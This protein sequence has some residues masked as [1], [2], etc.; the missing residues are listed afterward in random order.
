MLN[1]GSY[2]V[3]FLG[4]IGYE[5]LLWLLNQIARRYPESERARSIGI[6]SYKKSYWRTIKNAQI[7]LYLE[8]YFDLAFCAVLGSL[9]IKEY[10]DQGLM[11]D[12]LSNFTNCLEFGLTV[13]FTLGLVGFPL[14]FYI[15][16]NTNFNILDTIM[17]QK[18]YASMIEG[19]QTN[20]K[21]QAFY[22][23][24]FMVRRLITVIVL[25]FAPHFP[26][27]QSITLLLLSTVNLI[28]VT[29]AQPF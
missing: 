15:K 25:V 1:S 22:N 27:L 10:L 4:I 3:V 13:F 14:Y 5:I 19:L 12:Y 7:K 6:Y 28:Y 8:S 29:V 16:L 26:Y 20:Y 9:Q 11:G 2:F 17:F 21:S 24:F 23:L 18:S